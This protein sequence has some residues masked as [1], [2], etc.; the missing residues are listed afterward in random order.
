MEKYWEKQW[1]NDAHPAWWQP[2]GRIVGVA[3]RYVHDAAFGDDI[4]EWHDGITL[5]FKLNRIWA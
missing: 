5:A 1:R 4:K 2:R 3:F